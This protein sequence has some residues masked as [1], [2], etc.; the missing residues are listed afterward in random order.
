M[1]FIKKI[2]F[3]LTLF[4]L[5][6]SF[7]YALDDSKN[8]FNYFTFRIDE[9]SNTNKLYYEINYDANLDLDIFVVKIFH[10]GVLKDTCQ[11]S[12]KRNSDVVSEKI[13]CEVQKY[14]GGEYN[15]IS[16]ISFNG[17]IINFLNNTEI[18]P[19]IYSFNEIN[20]TLEFLDLGDKTQITINLNQNLENIQV[21]NLIPKEVISNLT[22]LNK[23]SLIYSK[24]D[25]EI[26]D[27]DPLIA[28]NVEKAPT[29]INYTIQKHINLE[30]QKNFVIEIKDE[31]L[32]NKFKW[33]IY[34]LIIIIIIFTFKNGLKK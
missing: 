12:L 9:N 5:F 14:G 30:D 26:L 15:F 16:S 1:D 17:T 10:N 8:S 34:I 24:L 28:W 25:Y 3:L 27:S 7:A 2:V 20:S 31:S 13:V 23:N 29:K 6:F 18:L 22:Q 33:I 19:Y 11:K 21:T 4:S 32:V